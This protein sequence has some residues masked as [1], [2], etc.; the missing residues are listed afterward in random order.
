[1]HTG[2][3]VTKPSLPLSFLYFSSNRG[4]VG[5]RCRDNYDMMQLLLYLF[6][7]R[8]VGSL[9]LSD[10]ARFFNTTYIRRECPV[11]DPIK[12]TYTSSGFLPSVRPL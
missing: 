6:F 3:L 10:L 1:M 5:C 8:I 11:Y 12:N 9:E 2:V 4:N 7:L